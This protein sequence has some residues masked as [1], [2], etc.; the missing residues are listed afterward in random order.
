MT[1]QELV[2]II[3]KDLT[4]FDLTVENIISHTINIM[5]TVQTLITQKGQGE[6]KK[7][8]VI[9]VLSHLIDKVQDTDVKDKLTL[10]LNTCVPETIDVVILV[11]SGKLDFGKLSKK[12]LPCCF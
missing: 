6:K 4:P 2:D 9:S 11:A 10:L 7:E 12:Y 8:L 3:L 5:H 1:T